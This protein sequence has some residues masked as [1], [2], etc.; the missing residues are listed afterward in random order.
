MVK[1]LKVII[2]ENI[3][4]IIKKYELNNYQIKLITK[5]SPST[6]DR[7][8]KGHRINNRKCI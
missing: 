7:I 8:V 2:D 1:R 3:G 5:I 6:I 4:W